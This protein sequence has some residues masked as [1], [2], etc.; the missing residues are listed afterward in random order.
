MKE[1]FEQI[2]EIWNHRISIKDNLLEKK[3]S[4]EFIKSVIDLI[5]DGKIR[6][7]IKDSEKWVIQEDVKKAIILYFTLSDS[8]IMKNGADICYD[9]IPLRFTDF[10]LSDFKEKNFRVVPGSIVRNG[11]YI[12]NNVVIMPSFINIGAYIDDKTMI[13]S[14][15]T[16]GSCAQ[17]GKNCHISSGVTIGGVLEPIEERPV[18]I[19]NNCFVGAGSQILE[20]MIIEENSIIG[21][22]V[23]LS[24]STRIIYRDSGEVIYGYVPK[25]SVVVRG[26]YGGDNHKIPSIS[27]AVII[28]NVTKEIKDKLSINEILRS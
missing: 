8:Y 21:S 19:E 25:N 4:L 6:A 13:D 17:I 18:I 10:T 16:I 7:A 28:K 15:V 12:G 1:I 20:G 22:G 5:N 3:E 11:V 26:S 2:N 23:I 9:K 27:C 14:C 24:A